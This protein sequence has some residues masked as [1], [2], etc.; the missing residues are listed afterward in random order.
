M[1][2]YTTTLDDAQ[3]EVSELNK[4]LSNV[5]GPRLLTTRFVPPIGML[6]R[7]TLLN[8]QY[9]DLEV[10]R[11]V[12]FAEGDRLEVRLH[13][14]KYLGFTVSDWEKLVER[15]RSAPFK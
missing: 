10:M 13:I 11:L 2:S 9:F 6:I 7:F 15:Q 12:A 4:S 3:I 8:K 1:I 5:R 14:P